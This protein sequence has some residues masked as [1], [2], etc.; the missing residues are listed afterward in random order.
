METGAGLASLWS[1][2]ADVMAVVAA[3]AAEGAQTLNNDHDVTV[4]RH[5][6]G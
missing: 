3:V 6:T 2:Y 1:E 5:L 4:S